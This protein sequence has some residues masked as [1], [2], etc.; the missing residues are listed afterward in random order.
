MNASS[1]S[2]PVAQL[3]TLGDPQGAWTPEKWRDYPGMGLGPEHIPELIRMVTDEDLLWADPESLEVWAPL[4]AWRALGQLHA[5]AAIEP[6]IGLLRYADEPDGE[7]IGDD[8][9]HVFAMIG[10]AAIPPLAEY[11]ADTSHGSYARAKVTDCLHEMMKAHPEARSEVQAVFV[12]QLERFRENEPALNGFLIWGLMDLRAVEA[13]PLMEQAFAAGAVDEM[14]VGDW[15]DVQVDLGLK[16]EREH[17]R[18]QNPF[19]PLPAAP[20]E[21]SKAEHLAR[22]AHD[23]AESKARSKRKQA[24]KSRKKN[25]KKK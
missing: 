24:S 3:L 8:L 18:R 16:A 5:E 9:P 23:R 14:I 21:R 7:I 13:A 20:V 25:R 19:F 17:P 4:H 22:Q 12:R 1:Y 11:L 15:E 6:L 10:P 2:P